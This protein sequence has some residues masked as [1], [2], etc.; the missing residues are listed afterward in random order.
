MQVT[1]GNCLP[2]GAEESFTGLHSSAETK[3]AQHRM[4]IKMDVYIQFD[5]RCQKSSEKMV[6]VSARR[7]SH[8]SLEKFEQ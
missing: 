4:L 3:Q 6:T 2:V 8:G 5:S 7:Y 1:E